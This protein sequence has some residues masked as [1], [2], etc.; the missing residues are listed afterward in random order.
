MQSKP[1]FAA[2]E[3]CSRSES[4]VPSVGTD[5]QPDTTGAPSVSNTT[6]LADATAEPCPAA[7]EGEGLLH[8]ARNLIGAL[9]LYCDL[10]SMPGVLKPEHSHYPEELRLL[11][12]RSHMLIEHM[13]ESLLARERAGGV[14]VRIS[15]DSLHE[16]EVAMQAAKPVGLRSVVEGRLGMLGRVAEGR[17]IDVHYGPAA[18]V[19]ILVSEEAVER[20][21]VNL[22]RNAAAALSRKEAGEEGT[23]VAWPDGPQQPSEMEI[24][25]GIRLGVGLLVNRADDPKPW[26]FRRVRLTVQ[27][28]GCGMPAGQV[29]RLLSG[30]GKP[31]RGSHGIGFRVVRELVAASGGDLRVTSRPGVGTRV[32]IEWPVAASDATVIL[33]ELG[34]GLSRGSVEGCLRPFCVDGYECGSGMRWNSNPNGERWDSC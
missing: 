24:T 17:S 33:D 2:F 23:G 13:M 29:E 14:C 30:G 34:A 31:S 28:S 5:E 21:L 4:G 15:L 19:P 20:I 12:G 16:S 18:T 32:Q 6:G 22:I 9:G 7:A 3:M 8:D 1:S 10:L 26:R 27:D 25:V 11:A